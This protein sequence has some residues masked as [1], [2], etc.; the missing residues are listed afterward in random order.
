MF[1]PFFIDR[2]CPEAPVEDEGDIP[3]WF[4]FLYEELSFPKCS[5]NKERGTELKLFV[6]DIN[7][8]GD[9]FAE[10]FGHGRL[11]FV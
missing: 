6:R 8:S 2:V 4:A 10:L 1:L 9:M 7:A 11:G 3:P 5:G